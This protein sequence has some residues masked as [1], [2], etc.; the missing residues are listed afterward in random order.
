MKRRGPVLGYTLKEYLLGRK[1]V[2]LETIREGCGSV[3]FP[4]PPFL[5][6]VKIHGPYA[7][8]DEAKKKREELLR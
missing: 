3:F 8:K 6:R 7:T 1:E 2:L 5:Y 4:G